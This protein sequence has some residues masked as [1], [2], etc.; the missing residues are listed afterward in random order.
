MLAQGA[1]A[2]RS[3]NRAKGHQL[4]YSRL[5][6][7]H[8]GKYY[9]PAPGGMEAH[10]QTLAR[11]QAERGAR[12]QVF[13]V[14]HHPGPTCV[15]RDGK[16]V[17]VRFRRLGAA[18]KIDL[19]PSLL[20][21]LAAVDADVLHVHVPNPTMILAVLLAK[22]QPP[23]VVTY[24]S[25]YVRQRI[26]A[27]LFRP[28]ERWFYRKVDKILATTPAY[29]A[30]SPFL[31]SQTERLIILPLGIDSRPFLEPSLANRQESARIRQQYQGPLWL[32]CGRLVYYKGLVHAIRALARVRGTLLIVGDGPERARLEAEAVGLGLDRRAIFLGTVSSVIPYYH[33]V[34][35]LWFPSNARSEAYGL[36]Q[37]EAMASGCPVINTAIPD[38]G[39]TWV[40]RHMETGLTVPMNDA[41]ALA[42][43]ARRLLV[44]P[45][46]RDRLA[47]A[48]RARAMQEFDHRV[49]AQRCLAIYRNILT[50]EPITESASLAA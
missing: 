31:R 3:K 37:L 42:D 29:I 47:A 21:R 39:V 41:G 15:E 18:A 5:R 12:V 44:E 35:A 16:V 22:P 25:D 10:L 9:P 23:I 50:G 30:G 49:M 28:L 19:C 1:N 36:V 38:S 17:V 26:R 11:A 24:Q 48:A 27:L 4:S 13:C 20:S 43:A 46:L 45:G 32:A 7:C 34:H 6:I 40:S 33:A 14:N 8:L 2:P